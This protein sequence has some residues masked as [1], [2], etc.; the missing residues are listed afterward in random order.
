MVRRACAGGTR[1][2]RSATGAASAPDAATARAKS[3][4]PAGRRRN[5]MISTMSP[6]ASPATP[7]ANVWPGGDRHVDVPTRPHRHLTRAIGHE[8]AVAKPPGVPGDGAFAFD[9]HA[10]RARD[11]CDHRIE[12]QGAEN[13]EGVFDPLRL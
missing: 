7:S 1:A 11:P 6:G 3:A 12:G 4:T 13:G 8:A 5:P 10:R 2:E 9:A